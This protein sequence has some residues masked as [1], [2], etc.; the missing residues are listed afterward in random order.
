MSSHKTNYSNSLPVVPLLHKHQFYIVSFLQ[1]GSGTTLA[2]WRAFLNL[3]LTRIKSIW[4]WVLLSKLFQVYSL[5]RCCQYQVLPITVLWLSAY[6]T[7]LSPL[8]LH[9]SSYY[10]PVFTVLN[11]CL[12]TPV[13]LFIS[14]SHLPS[15]VSI[16]PWQ[17]GLVTAFMFLLFMSICGFCFSYGTPLLW[18]FFFLNIDL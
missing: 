4:F 15:S 1:S 12:A 8:P 5:Q 13:F 7:S 11:V 6:L 14:V 10:S 16:C 9:F 17:V 18:S 2:T 3:L